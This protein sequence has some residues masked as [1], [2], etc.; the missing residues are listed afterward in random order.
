MNVGQAEFDAKDVMQMESGALSVAS[1]A[2]VESLYAAFVT[3]A[4]VG[5]LVWTKEFDRRHRLTFR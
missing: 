5:V 2:G 3:V 1:S 4:A